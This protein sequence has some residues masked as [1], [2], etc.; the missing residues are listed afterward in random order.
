MPAFNVRKNAERCGNAPTNKNKKRATFNR[1]P[2]LN[3]N[4]YYS[5]T[6]KQ[7]VV[8]LSSSY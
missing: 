8:D 4:Y 5:N 7:T 1:Q 2:F 6:T 3:F